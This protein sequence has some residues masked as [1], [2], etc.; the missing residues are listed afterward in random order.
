MAKISNR[1]RKIREDRLKY[2]KKNY[3]DLFA[4]SYDIGL[5]DKSKF[6]YTIFNTEF[7]DI[8]FYP[9]GNK[10]FFCQSET[11]KENGLNWLKKNLKY[12]KNK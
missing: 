2:F 9:K 11:W 6:L 3:L 4:L 1:E 8:E 12:Q 7:G 5:T 10:L